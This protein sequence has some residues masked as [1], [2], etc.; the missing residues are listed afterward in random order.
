V[1]KHPSVLSIY[2]EDVIVDGTKKRIAKLKAQ[3]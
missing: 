2:N 1:N 3:A